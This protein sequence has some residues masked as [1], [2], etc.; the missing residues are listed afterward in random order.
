MVCRNSSCWKKSQSRRNFRPGC[1]AATRTWS[2]RVSRLS[3]RGTH[4]QN[5]HTGFVADLVNGAAENQ[6]ADQA[7]AV[8]R[9]RDQIALFTLGRLEDFGRRITEREVGGD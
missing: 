4:Q 9:H 5:G 7:M 8:R 1:A 6:I 3:R 2:G